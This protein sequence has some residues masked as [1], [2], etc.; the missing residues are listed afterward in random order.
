MPLVLACRGWRGWVLCLFAAVWVGGL[1]GARAVES[2]VLYET[3]F[4]SAEGFDE[5]LT[6]VGQGGW[7]G[8]G[9]GGNGLLSGFMDGEGQQ[10]FLGFS[11]P[12]NQDGFLSLW[13]PVNFVPGGTNPPIVRF[14]VAFSIEDSSARTNRDDFRWSVYNS[15]GDRLFSL[16]FDNDSL[17]INTVL[18][19]GKFV[20]TGWSFTNAQP[21]QLEILVDFPGNVWSATLGGVVI[22]EG[23]PVT[24]QGASRDL[25]DVDAVWAVRRPGKAGDNYMV[26]DKYRVAAESRATNPPPRLKAL[27]VV[28]QGGFQVR[29]SGAPGLRYLLEG[30]RDFRNWVPL[31]TNVMPAEGFF[32]HLDQ[33]GVAV[34]FYRAREF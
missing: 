16:D 17:G 19:D 23:L 33:G 32:D 30:G 3:Q 21:Y 25:G 29:L 18:D 31:R 13:R 7:L 5:S 27:G 2:R 28:G 22:A 4:E 12:T 6:L 26:F 10:A 9:S 8:D 20:D 14:S 1:S 15:L 11:A 24:T 34:R